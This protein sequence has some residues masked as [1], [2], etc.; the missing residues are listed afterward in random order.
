MEQTLTL[1][2]LYQAY[3]VHD[4]R[5]AQ[6]IID[7]AKA[8]DPKPK[9]PPAQEGLRYS[10]YIRELKTWAFRHKPPQERARIRIASM[11]T[12]EAPDAGAES[13]EELG[14]LA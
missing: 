3:E 11:R 12:L 13:E 8:P 7:L 5:L 1:E 4:L 6:M 2:K 14:D 10:K 9:K